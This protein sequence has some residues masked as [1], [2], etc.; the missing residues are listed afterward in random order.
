MGL[1]RCAKEL[2][3]SRI[4]LTSCR[5]WLTSC[6]FLI[7]SVSIQGGKERGREKK[8]ER[9]T[10]DGNL[11]CYGINKMSFSLS[12]CHGTHHWLE[13]SLNVTPWIGVSTS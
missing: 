1:I 3:S 2:T 10:S 8:K 11:A 6:Y 13:T 9:G 12:I 5:T 7:I 4:E